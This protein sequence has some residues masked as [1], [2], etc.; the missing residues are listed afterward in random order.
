VSNDVSVLRRFNRRF[1]QRIGVLDDRFLG[2][3]RPLGQARLLFEVGR[4]GASVLELR[5]RLGLD[6]GYLSRLLRAL[7]AEGLVAVEADPDDGRRRVVRLT[8]LGQAEWAELDRRSND[9][10]GRLLEPLTT[11]QRRSL[12]Q[13]LTSAERLL[14]A[15]TIEFCA[16]D[17]LAEDAVGAMNAYF[18]ELDERF[19]GGFDPGDA[20]VGEADHYRPP[21]GVFVVAYSDAEVAGCGGVTTLDPG[22]GEI[23]RMWIAPGMRGLGLGRRMLAHLE[24]HSGRLGHTAV[25]LDSN[26]ALSEAISMYRSAGYLEI[27][28]YNENPYARHWFE[29]QLS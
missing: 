5:R 21:G 4:D 10:A 16:V 24:A 8:D 18:A 22:L 6:S 14:L 17:P 28:R 12:D 19:P 13:A 26:S 29:K 1:T 25:R 7:E 27:G 9:L 23:K 11:S 3:G 15:A 2:R 20:V